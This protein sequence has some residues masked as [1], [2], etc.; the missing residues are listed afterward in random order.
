MHAILL[1]LSIYVKAIFYSKF[2]FYSKYA[3]L[4]TITYAYVY[5]NSKANGV[6]GKNK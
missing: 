2:N 1:L 6:M 4:F 3:I 5:V